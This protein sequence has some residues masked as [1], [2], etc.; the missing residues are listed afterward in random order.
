M[1]MTKTQM[2]TIIRNEGMKAVDLEGLIQCD[3]ASYLKEI[4][5]PD[6][7]TRFAEIKVMAKAVDFDPDDAVAAYVEKV[8][9]ASDRAEVAAKAKVKREADKAKKQAEKDA[10]A[11]A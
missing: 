1:A 11:K 9:K 4:V 8:T 7:S 10:A 6:G 3:T 5:M 2:D